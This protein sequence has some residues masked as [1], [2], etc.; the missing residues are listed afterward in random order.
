[1]SLPYYKRFPAEDLGNYQIMSLSHDALGVWYLLA[2][3]HLWQHQA[4]IPDDPDYIAP[5]LKLTT[6]AWSTLRAEFLKR[7]LI[8]VIDEC[9][10]VASLREKWVQAKNY[11]ED[12]ADKRNKAIAA[13][14]QAN[15]IKKGKNSR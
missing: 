1:M 5:L 3:C 8:Q 4:R 14:K 12:Q 10:T 2:E 6:E 11:S 15:I 13:K 7:G 9:I